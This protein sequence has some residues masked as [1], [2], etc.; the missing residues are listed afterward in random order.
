LAFTTPPAAGAF[1]RASV[2]S[3]LT[4]EGR[5]LSA[6]VN[7]TFSLATG[8][9]T[10]ANVTG[11]AVTPRVSQ[12]YKVSVVIGVDN[13]SGT[14]EDIKVGFTFPSGAV[15]IVGSVGGTPAGVGAGVST[16]MSIV[17]TQVTSGSTAFTFGA[18]TGNTTILFEGWLRMGA[19]PGNLQVQAAQSTSGG[20][21]T[22]ILD[23]SMLTVV[24][25][26]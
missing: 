6:T 1:L 25:I 9:T 2:L 15:L 23:R 12:D 16:D 20:N 3:A 5:H 17:F 8:T 18:S 26:A 19:T 4:V 24:Q 10:L 21:A 7:P 22:R 13:V 14:T 11:L